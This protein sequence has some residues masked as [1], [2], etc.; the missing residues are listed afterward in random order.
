VPG[1]GAAVGYTGY[2]G[3]TVPTGAVIPLLPPIDEANGHKS[4]NQ[5]REVAVA[6]RSRVHWP[7]RTVRLRLTALY[8]ASSWRPAPA[9]SL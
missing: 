6:L 9:C 7:R 2:T 8:A 3:N 4:N 5:K 1:H